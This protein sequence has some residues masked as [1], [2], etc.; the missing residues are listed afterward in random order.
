MLIHFCSGSCTWVSNPCLHC[1]WLPCHPECNCLTFWWLSTDYFWNHAI[2]AQTRLIAEG[3]DH[4]TGNV[5]SGVALGGS[6][7]M[8]LAANPPFWAI[9]IFNIYLSLVHGS[10]HLRTRTWPFWTEP[11]VRSKVHHNQWTEPIVQFWVLQNPLKNQ[12]KPNLTIPMWDPQ[13]SLTGP[14]FCSDWIH[15]DQ[16]AFTAPHSNQPI[17]S[18]AFFFPSSCF[19]FVST[20]SSQGMRPLAPMLPF[21]AV[22]SFIFFF[23]LA[24]FKLLTLQAGFMNNDRSLICYIE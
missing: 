23:G 20:T 3:C 7:D 9:Q 12:T 17:F 19:K 8:G 10:D 11:T 22:L 24:S 18:L 4:L 16:W 6:Y 15:S 13:V 5:Y 14:W 1:L 21:T 2:S